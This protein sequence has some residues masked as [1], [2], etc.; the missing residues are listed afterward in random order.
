MFYIIKKLFG[1]AKFKAE[2]ILESVYSF[3][4]LPVCV[5]V[6]EGNV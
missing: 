3:T 5:C 2:L 4:E 6:C 1:I